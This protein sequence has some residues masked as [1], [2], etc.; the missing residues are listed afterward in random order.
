[1]IAIAMAMRRTLWEFAADL[2][3]RMQILMG[4]AMM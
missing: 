2:A 4:F 3:Q 1:M